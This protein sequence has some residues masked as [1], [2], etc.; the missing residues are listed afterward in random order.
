MRW[1]PYVGITR[2]LLVFPLTGNL[3]LLPCFPVRAFRG[4]GIHSKGPYVPSSSRCGSSQTWPNQQTSAFT[5]LRLRFSHCQRQRQSHDVPYLI[6]ACRKMG[7]SCLVVCVRMDASSSLT[8]RNGVRDLAPYIKHHHFPGSPSP[9][10]TSS[11][12]LY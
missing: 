9:Q 10:A 3:I 5:H 1:W 4:R 7:P 2:R 6:H 8:F 12:A 11:F